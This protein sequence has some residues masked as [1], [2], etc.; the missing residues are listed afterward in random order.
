MERQHRGS[1]IERLRR[2][3]PHISQSALV[4]LLKE[5]RDGNLPDWVVTRRD[6]LRA[7]EQVLHQ[8]TVY[9]TI[10]QALHLRAA[11]GV[12]GP[13]EITLVNLNSLLQYAFETREPFRAFL[14]CRHESHP[15]RHDQPWRLVYSD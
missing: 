9:G 5:S 3:L 10:G 8:R 13:I 1:T 15:S 4:A 14:M 12:D 2:S 7:Q 11:D 6:V